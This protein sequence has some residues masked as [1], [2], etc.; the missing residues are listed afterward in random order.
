MQLRLLRHKSPAF[1][2]TLFA[3]LLI[4]IIHESAGAPEQ[5]NILFILADDVGLEALGCYGGESYP[6]PHLDALAESGMRFNHCYSMPRCHPSRLALMTGRYPFRF[7]IVNWGDFPESAEARTFSNRLQRAGYQTAI[8]GK[9]QLCL[10]KDDP[11][12]PQRLGFQHSDLFG[13][14][15]GPRYYEPMI[16]RNGLVREDTQGHYGPDL[17]VRSLIDFMKANQGRPFLAYYSMAL[18]HAVTNDLE[19]P[20]P[21]GPLGRYDSYAEMIAEMDRAIGRLV[22]ALD[23]LDLREETLILFTSD[24]GTPKEMTIRANSH[25]ELIMKPI[26]SNQYGHEVMGGKGTLTDAGTRVPTI[27]NWKGTITP[28][29]IVDDL[30][31]FSDFLPTFC[32]LAGA[33]TNEETGLDGQS[34]AG[35]LLGTSSSSRTW[36]F[37]QERGRRDNREVLQW[38]RTTRWKLYSDGRLFDMQA[39][40]F[41]EH[42]S[43]PR[44]EDERQ[45]EARNRLDEILSSLTP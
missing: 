26:V 34:F 38:V 10:M 30:I 19:E 23:A 33:S 44:I 5:P 31:D 1:A 43:T 17:Y 15:E 24:N 37:S 29:Q 35:L 28:G 25:G 21:H 32:E 13:W 9:W 40:P 8:A 14:H 22:G 36:A 3:I 18:A 6:T 41:E 4:S 12:H 2:A 45:R 16:Y 20:V 7:G 39:D 11:L 27:A 42:P